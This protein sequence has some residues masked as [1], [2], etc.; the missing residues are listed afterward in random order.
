MTMQ[1][2][3]TLH[4]PLEISAEH[5]AYAGHFP[6]FPVL[7]GAVLIDAALNA[8]AASKRLDLRQWHLASVKFL[9]M[10][11]PGDALFLEHGGPVNG[12]IRF[13]IRI[14]DRKA[15][16]GTLLHAQAMEDSACRTRP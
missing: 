4:G 14:A 1:P 3:E 10:V 5:P 11:R 13:T 7:P 12:S 8:I 9:D 6:G 16:S 2:A 15:V